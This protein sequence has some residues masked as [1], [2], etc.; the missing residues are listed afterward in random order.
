MMGRFMLGVLHHH[1]IQGTH[2]A[3]RTAWQA[4]LGRPACQRS[5][6]AQAAA[7]HRSA[8][9]AADRSTPIAMLSHP[10]YLQIP[11]SQRLVTA[12]QAIVQVQRCNVMMLSG[13]TTDW[14]KAIAFLLQAALCATMLQIEHPIVCPGSICSRDACAMRSRQLGRLI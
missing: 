9:P 14:S 1:H 10:N 3:P 12:T 5:R 2:S 4:A 7:T 8:T 13:H 6:R 11:V